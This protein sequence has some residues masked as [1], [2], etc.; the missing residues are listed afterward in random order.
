MDV[1]NVSVT[2]AGVLR[3]THQ[4]DKAMT[5]A[6]AAMAHG[7]IALDRGACVG[8]DANDDTGVVS[9]N[10]SRASPIELR[11]RFGSF[12]RQRRSSRCTDGGSATGNALHV[13]SSFSTLA[14]V[15]EMS[16]PSNSR[17]PVSIS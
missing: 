3:A 16:S 1:Q 5:M 12:S 13:T 2:A 17:L 9:S 8:A 7:K 15:I 6:T 10:S 4:D 14:S 11:R